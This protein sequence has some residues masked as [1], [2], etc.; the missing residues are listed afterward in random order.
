MYNGTPVK[1]VIDIEAIYDAYGHKLQTGAFG[2][3]AL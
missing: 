2:E 1:P 3:S